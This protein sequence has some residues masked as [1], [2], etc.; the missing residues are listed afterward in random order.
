MSILRC[1]VLRSTWT[2]LLRLIVLSV[3][4]ENKHIGQLR[5]EETHCNVVDV[6]LCPFYS[7][8]ECDNA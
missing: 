5:D 1:T 4:Y 8:C 2:L 6:S 3:I 7:M